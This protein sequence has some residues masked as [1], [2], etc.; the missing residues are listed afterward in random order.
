M[1][2]KDEQIMKMAMKCEKKTNSQ[3]YR[4]KKFTCTKKWFKKM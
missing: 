2:K 3:K 1:N 4:K